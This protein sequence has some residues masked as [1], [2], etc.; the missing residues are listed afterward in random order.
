MLD[1]GVPDR[2]RRRPLTSVGGVPAGIAETNQG[3]LWDSG[4]V[5][6][7]ETEGIPYG[8]RALVSAQLVFWKVRVWNQNGQAAAWSPAGMW[9]MACSGRR[10][11]MRTGFPIRN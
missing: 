3:D 4:Q 2:G 5:A 8:G 9:T 10:T 1:A 11:G 6:S 7:D